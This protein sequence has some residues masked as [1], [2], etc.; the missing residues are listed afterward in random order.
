MTQ[1]RTRPRENYVAL[2]FAH[3]T[4]LVHVRGKTRQDQQE[5]GWTHGTFQWKSSLWFMTQ[6][7]G[8]FACLTVDKRQELRKQIREE[9]ICASLWGKGGHFPAQPRTLQGTAQRNTLLFGS[10]YGQGR[11][12]TFLYILRFYFLRLSQVERLGQAEPGSVLTQLT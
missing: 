3:K 4:M 11:N 12:E 5:R 10:Q 7:L 9:G 1:T 2:V 6:S 8:L